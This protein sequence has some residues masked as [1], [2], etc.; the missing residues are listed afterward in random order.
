MKKKLYHQ[1]ACSCLMLPEHRTRLE[2]RRR[3][4]ASGAARRRPSFDEQQQEQFQRLAEQSMR[5]GL[6]LKAEYIDSSSRHTLTGV[7]AGL[8]SA[9]G[10]IRF[11]QAGDGGIITLDAA[12]IVQ[13]GAAPPEN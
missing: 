11:Q 2:R 13:L 10:K 1:F 4:R 9:P 3:K 7:I 12:G 8:Q 6:L 5:S